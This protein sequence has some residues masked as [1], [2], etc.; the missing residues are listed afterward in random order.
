M[1]KYLTLSFLL[2]SSII[3][4]CATNS[5]TGRSQLTL[6]SESSVM[7]KSASMYT[8]MVESYDK[9][10]KISSDAATIERVQKITNRLV[11]RAVLYRP[12]TKKWQWQVNVLEDPE[13]I[14]ASCMPGGKMVLYTGL[15]EKVQ[16][17]DD[18]LAQVMGH[19]ISHALANHGVEKMSVQLLGQIA[20]AVVAVGAAASDRSPNQNQRY[21]NQQAVQN[22]SALAAA[23]FITLPNSRGAETEADKLGIELAAQAGYDPQAAVSLWHKMSEASGQKSKGD[24]WSTHPS[25][26][27]RIEALTALQEP[28]N[29]IYDQRKVIY[30]ADYKPSYLYVK[31]GSAE[32]ASSSNVRVVTNG[33][34]SLLD[35]TS[36]DSG[37]ALAFYSPE[38]EAFKAGSLE[39][40]CTSCGLKFFFKQSD[41]K[42]LY[43]HQ[44]WRGLQQAVTKLDYKI[45]LAYLYLGFAAEGLGLNES[46]KQYYQKAA[47]LSDTTEFSCAKAKMVKCNDFDVKTLASSKNR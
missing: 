37:K 8:A 7:N 5:M 3:S 32:F 15:L 2:L 9:K 1:K 27:N 35:D 42:K 28:M 11:D 18:E 30:T 33:E 4:G 47:E 25:P 41:L 13:V 22:A 20:V 44:D 6:V 23:A 12:E 26:P 16:P 14:N 43:D 45:D 40:K 38:Y 36:I 21:Q 39:L 46:S 19:E 29:K 34:S 24:F 31:M 10:G 17:T